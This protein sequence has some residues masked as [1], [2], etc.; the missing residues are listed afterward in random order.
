MTKHSGSLPTSDR[1]ATHGYDRVPPEPGRSLDHHLAEAVRRAHA[2][3]AE[4]DGRRAGIE[5]EVL[6]ETR[7][8]VLTGECAI[9]HMPTEMSQP[10]RLTR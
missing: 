7:Q 5:E 2:A 6:S 9:W 10:T 1:S 4:G 8:A 3:E